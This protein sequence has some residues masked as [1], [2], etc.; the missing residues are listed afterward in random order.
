MACNQIVIKRVIINRKQ[1][2]N[3]RMINRREITD[4]MLKRERCVINS[5]LKAKNTFIRF[6]IILCC[7]KLAYT[8]RQDDI[9]EQ[10]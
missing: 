8:Y 10:R 2:K 6:T 9:K 7:E 4:R 5:K 1:I 3:E